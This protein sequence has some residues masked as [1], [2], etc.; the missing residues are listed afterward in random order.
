[1]TDRKSK[2]L[3]GVRAFFLPLKSGKL[4]L[5]IWKTNLTN[6]GG[7]I[8]TKCD[9][10]TTHIIVGHGYTSLSSLDNSIFESSLHISSGE[11]S[12]P[13]VVTH[14]WLSTCFQRQRFEDESNFYPF[15]NKSK[16]LNGMNGTLIIGDETEPDYAEVD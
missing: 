15:G 6:V 13:K 5:R 12:L 9:K 10:N 1:M 16:S 7:E 3:A 2:Y 4:Q 8:S 14:F 11:K